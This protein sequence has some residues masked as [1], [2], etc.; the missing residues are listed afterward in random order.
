MLASNENDYQMFQ[1]LL[2]DFNLTEE[3]IKNAKFQRKYG[4]LIKESLNNLYKE[5]MDPYINYPVFKVSCNSLLS[6]IIGRFFF[7]RNLFKST[8]FLKVS[9]TNVTF[10]NNDFIDLLPLNEKSNVKLVLYKKT[11]QI[12]VKKNWDHESYLLDNEISIYELIKDSKQFVKYIGKIQIKNNIIE[13]LLIEYMSNGTLLSYIIKMIKKEKEFS[14]KKEKYEKKKISFIIDILDQLKILQ[15]KGILHRD[16]KPDNIF[17]DKELKAHIGDFGNSRLYRRSYEMT[18]IAGSEAYSAPETNSFGVY[19]FKSDIYSIGCIIYFIYTGK[20]YFYD[21]KKVKNKQLLK[22]NI[23]NEEIKE[24]FLKCIESNPDSRPGVDVILAKTIEIFDKISSLQNENFVDNYNDYTEHEK[25][26]IKLSRFY[27]YKGPNSIKDAILYLNQLADE[28]DSYAQ[29]NLGI[30]FS[31]PIYNCLDSE[32]AMNYLELAANQNNPLALFQLGL[33]YKKGLITERNIDKAIKYYEE[34]AE[35][36]NSSA[37]YNLGLLYY[38]GIYITQNINKSIY[39]FQLAANHNNLDAF[40]NLGIIYYTFFPQDIKKAILYLR[41][42]ANQN[43][44]QAQCV[45]GYMYYESPYIEHDINK[46]I[47]YLTLSANQNNISAL[48]FLG[49]I[50]LKDYL[51][52]RDINKAIHF[53]SLAAKQNEIHALY[54]LG[55]I[56][57][58]GKYVETNIEKSIHYWKQAEKQNHAESLYGLGTIYY[59]GLYVPRDICLSINYFTRAAEQNHPIAQFALGFIY[60]RKGGSYSN[61]QMA[62]HYLTLAADKNF[63]E[64]QYYLG[65]IYIENKIV[66]QDINRSIYFFSRAAN[67]GNSSAQYYLGRM[68]YEGKNVKQDINKSIYYLELSS[69]QNDSD[70]QY[71]LGLIC[72]IHAY[73]HET[74]HSRISKSINFD[75]NSKLKSNDNII[76]AIYYWELAAKNRNSKAMCSLGIFYFDGYYVERDINKAIQYLKNASNLNEKMAKNN[77]GIIYKNGFNGKKN[78]SLAIEYFREGIKLYDE[79][80]ILNYAKILYFDKDKQDLKKSIELL[81]SAIRYDLLIAYFFLYFIYSSGYE[82]LKNIEK[83]NHYRNIIVLLAPVYDI[84]ILL[85]KKNYKYDPLNFFMSVDFVYSLPDYGYANLFICFLRNGDFSYH[86]NIKNRNKPKNQIKEINQNFYDG[87]GIDI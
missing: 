61:T 71:L 63:S 13:S 5:K 60:Y 56:Y 70:S 66:K 30:I 44:S 69:K 65:L 48:S 50:Y 18:A 57:I 27:G 40:F 36:D 72:Y 7:K 41:Y 59:I 64:A 47:H 26:I 74:P 54:T 68:Y 9:S 25:Y 6:F 51:I 17:I 46:A 87:F 15:S 4:D 43:H 79:Y 19:S 67:L 1:A 81:E 12:F 20:H 80:S 58:E 35:L 24:I 83:A 37:Q 39:Y 31:D 11:C 23:E 76:R 49:K 86:S 34:A 21:Y 82:Q 29:A 84:V 78:I 10:N 45:F 52:P 53:Y 85:N 22:N 38:D 32:K 73:T 75:N 33:I 77:L 14:Q 55:K 42:A 3:I 16:L 62:I 8:D 28:G 2:N